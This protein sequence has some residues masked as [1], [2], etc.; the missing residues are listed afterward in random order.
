MMLSAASPSP[1]EEEIRL[2]DGVGLGVDFLAV[3]MRRD[4]LAVL[5]CDF[6]EGVFGYC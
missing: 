6:L 4:L 2:T 5:L 3:E 1:L